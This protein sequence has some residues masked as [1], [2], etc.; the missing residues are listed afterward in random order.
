MGQLKPLPFREVRRRLE[1]AGFSEVGQRGSHVKFARRDGGV[2]RTAV[3]PRHAEVA[4][5]T[6]RSVLRQAHISAEEWDAFA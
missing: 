5:G 4:A 3:V 2:V 6:L 1:A